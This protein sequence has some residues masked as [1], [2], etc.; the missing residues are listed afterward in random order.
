LFVLNEVSTRFLLVPRTI[1]SLTAVLSTRSNSMSKLSAQPECARGVNTRAHI[2][3]S[4]LVVLATSG[5]D[6]LAV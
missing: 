2:D 4:S 5:T 3:G 6:G 1:N